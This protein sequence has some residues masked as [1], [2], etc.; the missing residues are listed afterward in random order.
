[1]FLN[2][3]DKAEFIKEGFITYDRAVQALGVRGLVAGEGLITA[4]ISMITQQQVL[5]HSLI[6]EYQEGSELLE[7]KVVAMMILTDYFIHHNNI[8]A[9]RELALEY[10]PL[11]TNENIRDLKV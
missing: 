2:A 4:I 5:V 7:T 6:E 1:M 11:V 8:D 10:Q 9:I 3:D